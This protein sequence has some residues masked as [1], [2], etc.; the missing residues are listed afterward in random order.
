[1][2]DRSP[3]GDLIESV[4][5]LNG[6]SQEDIAKRANQRL[7]EKVLSKQSVSRYA[8]EYPLKSVPREAVVALAA[9]LG[10][11]PDRVALEAMRAMGFRPPAAE[12]TTA[13]AVKRDPELDES[14]RQAILAVLR[15]ALDRSA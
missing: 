11:S 5:A 15:A 14:T 7:G 1:M 4:R 2:P 10:V 3:L 12:L 8:N 6:W 13:E 9:G